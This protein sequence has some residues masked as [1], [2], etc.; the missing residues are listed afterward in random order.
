[1]VHEMQVRYN[2]GKCKGIILSQTCLDSNPRY[3]IMC[4]RNNDNISDILKS[5]VAMCCVICF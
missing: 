3:L 1:M 5:K 4:N 2:K